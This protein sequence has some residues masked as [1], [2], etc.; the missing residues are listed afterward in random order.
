MSLH[1]CIGCFREISSDCDVCPHCKIEYPFERGNYKCLE[2]KE[3]F[4]HP[5]KKEACNKCGSKSYSF[6]SLINSRLWN[7]Y[8]TINDIDNAIS[9]YDIYEDIISANKTKYKKIRKILFPLIFIFIFTIIWITRKE[10]TE[11]ILFL[12]GIVLGVTFFIWAMLLSIID[13]V[14]YRFFIHKKV[15]TEYQEQKIEIDIPKLNVLSKEIGI[16][17]KRLIN[18]YILNR[19]QKRLHQFSN[20]EILRR[21]GVRNRLIFEDGVLLR[22]EK[23]NNFYIPPSK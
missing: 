6:V 11:N 5:L 10:S 17:N 20:D 14:L 4:V 3:D 21:R 13:W 12:I 1:L 16:E 7:K 8:I 9:K 23:N 2:C 22:I 15:L 19:L 18:G